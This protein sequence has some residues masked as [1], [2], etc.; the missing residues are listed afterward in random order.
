MMRGFGAG[1]FQVE[2]S[3]SIKTQRLGQGDV[4]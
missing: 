1:I 3:R 4:F 2:G